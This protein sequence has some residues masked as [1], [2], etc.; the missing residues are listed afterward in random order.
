[1]KDF[2]AVN[3]I[4]N[5]GE[6]KV[7]TGPIPTLRRRKIVRDSVTYTN[8]RAGVSNTRYRSDNS[9]GRFHIT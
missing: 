3:T 9:R 1:M 5:L 8:S 6:E 4:G 7:L 2:K